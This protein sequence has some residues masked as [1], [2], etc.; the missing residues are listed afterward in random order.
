MKSRIFATIGSLTLLTAAA[1]AQSR[2]AQYDIPFAFQV[3]TTVLPAG[4]Y[5]V[6]AQAAQG[7]LSI[8]CFD[9]KAGVMVL[10]NAISAADMSGKTVLVFH[11]YGERYFL[12][13]AWTSGYDQGRG[14][15]KSKAEREL[16]RD[17]A[18]DSPVTVAVRR[19]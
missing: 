1:F 11:R 14:L 9:C 17:V 19:R 2:V 6:H 8:R 3:G 5:D 15:R 16:A 13:A 18:Q 12:S 7:A 10:T 4:H